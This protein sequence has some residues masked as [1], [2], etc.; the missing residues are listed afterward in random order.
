MT[1]SFLLNI[2]AELLKCKNT[3][4]FWLTISGAAFIPVVNVIK[5]IARPDYFIPKMQVDPW[6]AFLEYNWQIAAGFLLPMYVI[7]VSSLVV[8]IE[9]RNGTWKQVY[10]SPRSYLDIYV[11]KFLILNLLILA[12][13]VLFNVF[14]IS[15]GYITALLEHRYLFDVRPLPL[16]AMANTSLRMYSSVFAIT[17]IQ[18]CLSLQFKNFITALGIGAGLFTIGF[19]IRQWEHIDYYPYMFPFLV[20]FPNPGLPPET[21]HH[22]MRHSA[23]WAVLSFVAGYGLMITKKVKG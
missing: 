18:Y 23:E 17:V 8:Q 7:L 6:G 14:I 11:S 12:C 21:A 3:P 9:Y 1:R 19:M 22:A 16:K 15:S 10:A 5:C 13:F 20:Y 4:A 2:K